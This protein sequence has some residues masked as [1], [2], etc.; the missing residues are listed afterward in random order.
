MDNVDVDTV[1]DECRIA[2][3]FSQT[4]SSTPSGDYRDKNRLKI[5]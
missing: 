5:Q 4:D 3:I 2:A 1:V